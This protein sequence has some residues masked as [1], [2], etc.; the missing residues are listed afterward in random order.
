[1]RV[2]IT[3][4]A[5]FFGS[6]AA[7]YFG[8]AEVHLVDR[9]GQ[10]WARADA[11]GLSAKRHEAN[12]LDRNATIA[13][14][15]RIRPDIVVHL[16]WHA[17][18]ATYL[19]S[20]ENLA[21]AQAA[22]SLFLLARDLGC[23]RFCGAGTCLEYDTSARI[24]TEDSAT[25]PDNL[26]AASKL[27][28]YL[29]LESAA[30]QSGVSFAWMRFFY[31][32]GPYEAPGRLVSS[33]LANM[34][35]G[36][37]TKITPGE[38]MRDFVHIDDVGRAIAAVALAKVEGVVNIGTGAVISVKDAVLELAATLGKRELIEVGALPY[39]E[40]DAMHVQADITK[41]RALGFAPRFSAHDGLRDTLAWA[42]ERREHA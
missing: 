42:V 18:P 30:R 32:Y 28:T 1:M 37:P 3:G 17:A 14:L 12:L 27:A 16:A 38:Q 33:A 9:V 31:P 10:S 39:R 41:L 19:T 36:R 25:K 13:V 4:G 11:L 2:L 35:A 24:L 40:G 34:L 29:M 5:G 15:G 26:Y 21:H 22:T 7:K 8:D 20:D 23:T 6:R